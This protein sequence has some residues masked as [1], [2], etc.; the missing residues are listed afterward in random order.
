[1]TISSLDTKRMLD[2]LKS[3]GFKNVTEE[4][5]ATGLLELAT[6]DD[7]TFG[8]LRGKSKPTSSG[9]GIY[10]LAIENTEQGNGDFKRYIDYLK[11]NNEVVIIQAVVNTRL[12]S[13]LRRN[14]FKRSAKHKN[15]YIY[16]KSKAV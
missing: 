4:M 15:D 10:I 3:F 14:G 9:D 1:M 2:T 12:P 13:W 11:D 7:I 16:R 5:V 8:T 6:Y